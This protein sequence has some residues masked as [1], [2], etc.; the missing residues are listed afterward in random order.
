MQPVWAVQTYQPEYL[1]LIV[2]AHPRLEKEI[3]AT[4]WAR[5]LITNYVLANR[6]VNFTPDK[7]KKKLKT[8][9]LC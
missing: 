2:G 6:S 8:K 3:A 4:N 7:V 1:A 5:D 9:T